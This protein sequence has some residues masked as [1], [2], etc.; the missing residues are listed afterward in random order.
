VEGV[1]DHRLMFL[2]R[3]AGNWP[4]SAALAEEGAE[5]KKG[6]VFQRLIGRYI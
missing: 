1:I 2:K 5:I 3:H 6:P 4:I